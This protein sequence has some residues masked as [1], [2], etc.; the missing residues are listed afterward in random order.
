MVMLYKSWKNKLGNL[1]GECRNER[2][3]L[4]KEYVNQGGEYYSDI[5]LGFGSKKLMNYKESDDV[6]IFLILESYGGGKSW[7]WHQNDK[8]DRWIKFGK[9]KRSLKKCSSD[10]KRYYLE[11]KI[12]SYHQKIIRDLISEIQTEYTYFISDLVKC[13]VDND[14][15]KQASEHCEDLLKQQ[16]DDLSPRLLVSF[17]VPAKSFIG[18][19]YQNIPKTSQNFSDME[20]LTISNSDQGGIKVI[21]SPFPSWVNSNQF[22]EFGGIYG[23]EYERSE[24]QGLLQLIRKELG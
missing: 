19:E 1:C 17:G 10:L 16:I 11:K 5:V 24:Q 4:P 2:E 14:K 12:D 7:D 13:Y 20:G 15:I 21:I 6:D 23:Y 18:R 8:D 22:E 9:G 3:I